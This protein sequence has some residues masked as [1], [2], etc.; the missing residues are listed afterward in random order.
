MIEYVR[1]GKVYVPERCVEYKTTRKKQ[2]SKDINDIW[3][4]IMLAVVVIVCPLLGI[5][6]V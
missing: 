2:K 1:C 4:A 5:F 6:V 3:L